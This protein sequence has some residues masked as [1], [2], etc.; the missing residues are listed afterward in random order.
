MLNNEINLRFQ[1]LLEALNKGVS[2][3]VS[4]VGGTQAKY[5][6]SLTF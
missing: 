3:L 6:C 5:Y 2:D 1:Q 4:D